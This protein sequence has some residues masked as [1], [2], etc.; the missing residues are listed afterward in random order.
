MFEKV[1]VRGALV[2]RTI[3]SSSVFTEAAVKNLEYECMVPRR[4]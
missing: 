2:L 1:S 3:F 4:N